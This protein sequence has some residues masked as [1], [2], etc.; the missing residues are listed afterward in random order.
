MRHEFQL[1]ILCSVARNTVWDAWGN[2]MRSDRRPTDLHL[3]DVCVTFSGLLRV[4]MWE[5]VPRLAYPE[6]TDCALGYVHFVG[7]LVWSV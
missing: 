4:F 7:R 6:A 1:G 5:L 3:L 2:P